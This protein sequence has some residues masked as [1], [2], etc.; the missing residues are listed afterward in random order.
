MNFDS[1]MFAFENVVERNSLIAATVFSR[2]NTNP[3]N[4]DEVIHAFTSAL[5]S[6]NKELQI[7]SLRLYPQLGAQLNTLGKDSAKEHIISGINSL[8]NDTHT[9]LLSLN[10][11]YYKKFGFPCV[12]C[13]KLSNVQGIL[14]GIQSRIY[15]DKDKEIKKGFEEVKKIAEIRIRSI[16]QSELV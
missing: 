3:L 2:V 10:D 5:D 14:T 11:L 15:N 13:V 12:I 9:Q 6:Y 4:E 16:F 1:F 7:S 8:D